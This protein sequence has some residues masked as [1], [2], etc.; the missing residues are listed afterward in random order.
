MS[1]LIVGGLLALA[2]VAIVGAVLLSIDEE[3]AEKQRKEESTALSMQTSSAPQA[4]NTTHPTATLPS[5]TSEGLPSGDPRTTRQLAPSL[6][7][8]EHLSAY[9]SDELSVAN[10][11]VYITLLN[12]QIQAISGEMRSLVQKASELEQRLNTLSEMIESQQYPQDDAAAK[13]PVF[14]KIEMSSF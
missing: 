12:G 13:N 6:D 9:S 7:E 4:S 11:E 10:E 14:R 2:L 3:S 1:I 8:D 5:T